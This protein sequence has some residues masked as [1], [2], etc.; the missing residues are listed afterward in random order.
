MAYD[1]GAMESALAAVVGDDSPLLAE[2][3]G[4]F[5]D[6][7]AWHL[8]Q[9]RGATT[10]EAWTHAALRMQGLAASFGALRVIDAATS[11]LVAA[12]ADARALR[13]IERA[14]AALRDDGADGPH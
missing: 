10:V 7:A 3:R 6:S 9:L 14:L 5:F 8:A 13:R 12:P 1:P 11:A 4:A 2:L